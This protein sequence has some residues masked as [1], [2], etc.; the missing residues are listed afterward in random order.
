M[1]S[2]AIQKLQ[3]EEDAFILCMGLCFF[4]SYCEGQ[5]LQTSI[6]LMGIQNSSSDIQEC[7]EVPIFWAHSYG[8]SPWGKFITS[9][10]A[11]IPR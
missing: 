5:S 7:T 4:F 11:R 1:P 10:L 9:L 3:I 8:V 6:F 2:T